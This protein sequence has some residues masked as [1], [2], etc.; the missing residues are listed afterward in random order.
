MPT[1]AFVGD[2]R[3]RPAV[4]VDRDGTIAFDVPYC[5]RVEDFHLIPGV[6]DAIARLARS[7]WAIVVI[8][9]QSG[10]ARGF[11]S[12]ETLDAIHKKMQADLSSAGARI[13]GVYHCPHHPSE[14][15]SCRKPAP[16]MIL[17]AA[18]E[19]VLDLR[20]SVM[21]GDSVS[22]VRAGQAAGCR[23][24]LIRDGPPRD[25][26]TDVTPDFVARDF[27]EACAWIME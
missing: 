26:F 21:V 15:C 11:F 6:A 17:Q 22:D 19:L 20:R 2:Q 16:S 14:G 8:T 5:S 9:N 1:E 10:I 18:R 23:T 25:T 13:D 4:F 3:G 7:G 27:Q 24:V 12:E